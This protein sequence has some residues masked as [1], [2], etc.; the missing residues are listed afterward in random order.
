M[1]IFLFFLFVC[2][3]IVIG[4]EIHVNLAPKTK[5]NTP[6]LDPNLFKAPEP[7]HHTD[8]EKAKGKYV[9]IDVFFFF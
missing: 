6:K 5:E 7:W 1:K 9:F 8:I 3:G 2:V 4:K